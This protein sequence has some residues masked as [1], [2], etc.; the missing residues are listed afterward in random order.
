MLGAQ[1]QLARAHAEH[2]TGEPVP[3]VINA[4][5]LPK[6]VDLAVVKTTAFQFSLSSDGKQEI[7]VLADDGEAFIRISKRVVL[8]NVNSQHWYRSMQPGGGPIPARLKSGEQILSLPPDWKPVAEQ[9]G[10][11]WYD[12]RLVDE[13]RTSLALTLR[14]NGQRHEASIQRKP[15]VFAGYWNS[16][17]TREPQSAGVTALIPGLS[18]GAISL[19]RDPSS[20]A[21]VEVLDTSGK[22]FLRSAPEGYWVNTS[23]PWF[24]ELGLHVN[25]QNPRHY[26]DWPADWVMASGSLMLT[27]Q[28]PR[29][30][31][32]G[33]T[34]KS[35][36]KWSI[37]VRML[38]DGRT[39][40]FTGEMAWR[41]AAR[42]E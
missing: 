7:E 23:H 36:R 2:G 30:K 13:S 11:G 39:S 19:T 42:A 4:R 37:P 33:G 40:H 12:A 25:T 8:A 24:R 31:A 20:P 1:G 29:L 26:R 15:L 10:F 9:A 14:I 27:Y 3:Q 38:E 16:Y 5:Q 22:A 41:A 35:I 6:G 32:P 28:D 18:T 34:S 21:T 17:L